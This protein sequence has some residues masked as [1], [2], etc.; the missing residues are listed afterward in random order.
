MQS[1]TDLDLNF[2]KHPGTGDVTRIFNLDAIKTAM[3]NI[4]AGKPFEKP[5]DEYYGTGIRQLLFTLY[6][7]MTQVILKKILTEKIELYEPRV[8]IDDVKINNDISDINATN[9]DI[10]QL[11][12]DIYYTVKNFGPQTLRLEMERMR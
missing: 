8:I 4:I 7:P 2:N 10:N 3:R 12:V 11:T 1:Y 9:Q 6:S 5:F